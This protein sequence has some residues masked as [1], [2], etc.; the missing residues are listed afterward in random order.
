MN[1]QLTDR[2]RGLALALAEELAVVVGA[3]LNGAAAARVIPGAAPGG[4]GWMLRWRLAGP[5]EG[6]LVAAIDENMGREF[7]RHRSGLG[8]SLT[9]VTVADGL[10]ELAGQVA[11]GLTRN[12]LVEGATLTLDGP[13][14]LDVPEPDP[15]AL[16]C[17][18]AIP[19]GFRMG[20]TCRATV[21]AA[22]TVAVR[23]RGG[24]PGANI[25][26]AATAPANLEVILDIE[27]PLVV[28][29]AQT[30]LSLQALSR[31]GP[32]SVIDLDRSPEDVVD[33]L[34]NGRPIA[35]GEVVVAAGNYGVRI[36]EVL[37]ADERIR[38]IAS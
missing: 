17:E 25:R 16:C 37:N 29:F 9:D 27:L 2:E 15:A 21:D 30:S 18:V 33:V 28:R 3:L 4:T 24:S 10:L 12:P 35:R 26:G 32:G 36:T 31:L 14:V 11:A 7:V 8:P 23:E 38:M 13:P 34:V 1:S 19:G 6:N 5:F 20:V 22:P